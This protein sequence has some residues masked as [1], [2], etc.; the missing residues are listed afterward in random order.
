MRPWNKRVL[1]RKEL[2]RLYLN[3]RLS[4]A[5]IGKIYECDANVILRNLREYGILTRKLSE[6]TV[7]VP[8]SREQLVRWYWKDGLSMFEIADRLGCT[9]SAVVY[10]F[11]KLGIKSRGHLGLTPPL[12][13]TRE[14]W[15]IS[16][17]K[18]YLWRKL[19]K[20]TT[21]VRGEW[22]EGLM[23]TGWFPGE[24]QIGYASIKS[25]I[26]PEIWRRRLT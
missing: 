14:K 8:I 25:Q 13:L 10:K 26:F 9:H 12:N 22:R 7:K 19:P 1:D 5:K 20:F 21:E 2:R 24:T 4:L 16:T 11:Q 17:I 15:N 6:A 23:I 3:E 18:D